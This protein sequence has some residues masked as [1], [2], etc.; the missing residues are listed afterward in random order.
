MSI[1]ESDLGTA[2]AEARSDRPD[3]NSQNLPSNRYGDML[4][5]IPII[6]TN[7]K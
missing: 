3:S 4:D 5:C 1:L 6:K 7:S 2:C